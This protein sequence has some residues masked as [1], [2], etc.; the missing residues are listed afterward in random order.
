MLPAFYLFIFCVLGLDFFWIYRV[1]F[2]H[3]VR[4]VNLLTNT[5]KY[6]HERALTCETGQTVSQTIE[7]LVNVTNGTREISIKKIDS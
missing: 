2:V 5:T 1:F 6:F 3:D 4:H 7:N